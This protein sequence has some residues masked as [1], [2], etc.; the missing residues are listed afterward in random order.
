MRG[1]TLLRTRMSNVSDAD[2]GGTRTPKKREGE[3]VSFDSTGGSGSLP[4]MWSVS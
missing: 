2:G 3:R 4:P 1:R